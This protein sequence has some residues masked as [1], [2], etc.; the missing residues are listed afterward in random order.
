MTEGERLRGRERAE[1]SDFGGAPSFLASFPNARILARTYSAHSS[2]SSFLPS[3]LLKVCNSQ[4]P[5]SL[6]QHRHFESNK[7]TRKRRRT[8]ANEECLSGCGAEGTRVSDLSDLSGIE[9]ALF[10][11]PYQIPPE[12]RRRCSYC[13]RRGWMRNLTL[14]L[15][16]PYLPPS[17]PTIFLP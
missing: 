16:S 7:R 4:L 5:L 11:T 10:Y 9:R 8:R 17:L 14:P 2:S 13:S 3:F 12:G 15:T 6:S 1:N